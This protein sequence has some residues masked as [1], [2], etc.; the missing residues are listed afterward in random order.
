MASLDNERRKQREPSVKSKANNIGISPAMRGFSLAGQN[1]L[2]NLSVT[3]SQHS[4]IDSKNAHRPKKHKEN[5]IPRYNKCNNKV[6]T[7]TFSQMSGPSNELSSERESSLERVTDK[8]SC[9]NFS[10]R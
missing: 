2:S 8:D 10:H 7:E 5:N 6:R 3:N 4:S 9:S 1:I